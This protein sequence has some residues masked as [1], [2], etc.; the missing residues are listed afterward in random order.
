MFDDP[1]DVNRGLGNRDPY[2]YGNMPSEGSGYALP[3]ALLA[4]VVIIGGL[5]HSRRPP[6]SR[7]QPMIRP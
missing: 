3:I 5:S 1:R 4:I 6:I 2:Q 7:P